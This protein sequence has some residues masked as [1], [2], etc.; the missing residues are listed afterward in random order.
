[1]FLVFNALFS[2]KALQLTGMGLYLSG[3]RCMAMFVLLFNY[4]MNRRDQISWDKIFSAI[5][6]V[7]GTIIAIVNLFH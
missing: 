5:V 7:I 1:M 4:I 6:I 3:R 2:I